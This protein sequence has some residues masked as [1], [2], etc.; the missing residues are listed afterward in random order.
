MGKTAILTISYFEDIP[1]NFSG[2][3]GRAAIAISQNMH[4]VTEKSKGAYTHL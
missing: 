2:N 4:T 1:N 3:V